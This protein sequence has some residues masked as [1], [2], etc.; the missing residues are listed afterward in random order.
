[1]KM[2]LSEKSYKS[3]AQVS[4]QAGQIRTNVFED[5]SAAEGAHQVIVATL[6]DGY[7]SSRW[8]RSDA[9]ARTDVRHR[10]WKGILSDYMYWEYMG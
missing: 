9:S 10:F 5:V 8:G 3:Y 2:Q 4:K 6:G 1:M 7:A